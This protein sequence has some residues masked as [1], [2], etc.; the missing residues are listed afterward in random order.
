LIEDVAEI[1]RSEIL[2][3][4]QRLEL[5]LRAEEHHAEADSARMQQVLW[6]LL[7]NAIKFTGEGGAITV[8]TENPASGTLRVRVADTGV[9]IDSPLLARIFEPFEQG[10]A[11]FSHR[12]SGLGLGLS[13][14]KTLVDL[15]GGTIRAESAGVRQG[16]VFTVDLPAFR[17]KRAA[18]AL[19]LSG[20][21]KRLQQ[22]LS[23]LIV[24]DHVD[25]ADAL[26]QLLEMEGHAVKTAG[27]I[28]EAIAAFHDQA[29][30][31]LITDLGLPDGSGHDL[32][33]TLR[34]IRPVRGIVLSGYGMDSDLAMSQAAGF[35]DHLTKPVNIRKLLHV[36]EKLGRA[37][38]PELPGAGQR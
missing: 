16:A 31:L 35:A 24:E 14:S 9:G 34:Q 20:G 15:H 17:Q 4:R 1:C 25:T 2:A 37:A 36:I 13:I 6:N 38:Q 22:P 11:R 32:M 5:D 3:K 29:F 28:A 19:R 7:K 26:S 18:R 10:T 12:Q 23:I 21:A 8:T 33:S 27:S 30:D